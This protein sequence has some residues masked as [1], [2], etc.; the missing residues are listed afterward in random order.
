MK[1]TNVL[2]DLED[3]QYSTQCDVS[4]EGTE[5][6]ITFSGVQPPSIG[7]DKTI[8]M[9][10]EQCNFIWE[11]SFATLTEMAN[12]IVANLNTKLGASATLI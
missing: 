7:M 3:A 5:V 4:I 9:K 12:Y 2:I 6:Q 1:V 10:L 8:R 11:T